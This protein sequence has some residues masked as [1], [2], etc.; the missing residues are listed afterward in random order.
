M[1]GSVK[2]Y[3]YNAKIYEGHINGNNFEN[4]MYGLVTSVIVSKIVTVDTPE[5]HYFYFD[6]LI[7]SYDLMK[8]SKERNI[9]ATGMVRFNRMKKCPMETDN[10]IKK[11]FS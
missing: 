4:D 9:L 10:E 6:N 1:C 2:S 8:I 11:D 5:E 7:P 3:F